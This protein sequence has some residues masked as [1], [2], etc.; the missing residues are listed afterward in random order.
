M[1]A[2]LLHDVGHLPFSHGFERVCSIS[3][4]E[5]SKRIILGDSE[6]HRI[7]HAAD[8][9]LPQDV[10]DIIEYKHKNGLLNPTGTILVHRPEEHFMPDTIGNLTRTDQREYGR[11]IV[12]FYTYSR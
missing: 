5:F 11:S 12:D 10:A 8:P 7:L 4:E 6:I 3:H 2:G 1:I 9:N